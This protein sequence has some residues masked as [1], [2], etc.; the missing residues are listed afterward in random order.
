MLQT[1]VAN[2]DVAES[3]SPPRVANMA[4]Q[5]GLRAGCSLDLTTQDIDGCA[6]DFNTLE[7]RNRAVRRVLSDKPFLLIGSPLCIV[8]STMNNIN[9]ARMPLE[10]VKE[11]FA[12]AR[13]HFEFA[14]KLYQLQIQEGRCF[15]HGHPASASSCEEDCAK[16]ILKAEGVENVIG[17]QCQYGF[18]SK[19]KN[20]AGPARKTTA[21]MTNAP[22][23]ALQLKR[24]CPNQQG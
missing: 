8:Y 2:M 5:M 11:R 7:T 3:Y 1:L 10:P 24:R 23:V 13:E 9:H 20:G 15:L 16:K 19:D 18:K 22:C 4:R 17:D 21:F 6:W 14:T 12:H